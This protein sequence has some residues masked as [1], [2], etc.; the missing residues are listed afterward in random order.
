MMD[1]VEEI[2]FSKEDLNEICNRLGKEISNDY[3]G[4]E[5]VLVGM[6][7]GA[8]L[9]MADL[10]RKID[11]PCYI[12]FMEASSYVGTKNSGGEVKI[13]KYLR[14]DIKGMDVLIVEDILE[15]GFTLDTVVKILEKQNPKS[16]KICTL[17]DKPESRK[18]KNIKADYV[19]AKIPKDKFVIGYG[20]D[21]NEKYRNLPFVGVMNLKYAD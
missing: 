12:D 21:Y 17:L 16:L 15:S 19:G 14:N 7:K 5:L 18:V 3:K 11:I 10:I 13:N 9:F 6:L 20:F 2:L 4:K 1:F 8:T